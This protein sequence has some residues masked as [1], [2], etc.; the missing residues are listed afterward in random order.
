MHVN[1]ATCKMGKLG[2][3]QRSKKNKKLKIVEA[4]YS[5]ESRKYAKF[6]FQCVNVIFVI[7]TVV[8]T[9]SEFSLSSL[10][11]FCAFNKKYFIFLG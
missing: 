5:N 2:K 7:R 3:L 4:D 6:Y 9:E 1:I 11:F 10:L 8:I